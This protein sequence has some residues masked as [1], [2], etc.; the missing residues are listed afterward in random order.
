MIVAYQ[1]R[2]VHA[3]EA[4][5][6]TA[7]RALPVSTI[8]GRP[9]VVTMRRRG[10]TQ[11]HPKQQHSHNSRRCWRRCVWLWHGVIGYRRMVP[12]SMLMT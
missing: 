10:Q 9:L 6:H 2:A 12:P 11:H 5:L 7:L 8:A 3:L 4:V 1:E